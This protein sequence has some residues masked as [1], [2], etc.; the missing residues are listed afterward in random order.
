MQIR[1]F[2]VTAMVACSA[3]DL[4]AQGPTV[5][6]LCPDPWCAVIASTGNLYFTSSMAEEFGPDSASFYRTSKTATVGGEG[7]LYQETGDR[8]GAYYFGKPVWAY[9]SGTYY[10]YF[11]ANYSDFGVYTSQIKRVP[12]AGG[13]AVTIG[14]PPGYIGS[15][16]LVTDGLRLYWADATGIRSMPIAGGAI[17]TL[18]SSHG[19]ALFLIGGV[20]ADYLYYSV[21][22]L[23]RQVPKSGGASATLITAPHVV[24]AIYAHAGSVTTIHWGEKDGAVRSLDGYLTL[25][26]VG[27]NPGRNVTSVGFDGARMLWIDCAQPGDYSCDVK[28][29]DSAG[30]RVV[31]SGCARRGNLQWDAASMY[32]AGGGAIHRYVY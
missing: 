7:L 10:G 29:K 28:V 12:L 8:P 23:I 30:I 1:M 27:P 24:T 18:V 14:Y 13:S 20:D 19:T 26:H 2:W 25:T 11:A 31:S 32:W 5:V 9:T 3:V 6:A 15:K 4:L 16:D 22:S 17:A 21:G